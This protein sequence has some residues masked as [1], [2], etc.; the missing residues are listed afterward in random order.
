MA[1]TTTTTTTDTMIPVLELDFFDVAEPIV[2]GCRGASAGGG[3][4]GRE[5]ELS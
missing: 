4:G 5:G 2:S 1:I 3:R